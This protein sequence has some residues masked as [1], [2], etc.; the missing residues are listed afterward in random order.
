MSIAQFIKMKPWDEIK[1]VNDKINWNRVKPDIDK[2]I[3]QSMK[4]VSNINGWKK[5]I[6]ETRNK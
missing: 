6:K 3:E 4:Q 1:D 2:L 5:I